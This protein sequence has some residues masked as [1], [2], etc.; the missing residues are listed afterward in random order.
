MKKLVALRIEEKVWARFLTAAQ[1]AG[2][3]ASE[4]VRKFVEGQT[5]FLEAKAKERA[6]AV[7]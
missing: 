5:P 2:S 6:D 7:H 1:G 4:Q 3:S